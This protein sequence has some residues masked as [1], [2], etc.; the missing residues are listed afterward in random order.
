MEYQLMAFNFGTVF[1]KLIAK[2]K[3]FM[4]PIITVIITLVVVDILYLINRSMASSIK[5]YLECG[6]L[7]SLVIIWLLRVFGI[8]R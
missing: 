2:L 5:F 1:N 3:T 6:W 7:L 8:C 4:T